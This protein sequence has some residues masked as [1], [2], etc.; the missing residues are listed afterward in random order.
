[1][2][3]K[4]KAIIIVIVAVILFGLLVATIFG[5]FPDKD[6]EQDIY[7]DQISDIILPDRDADLPENAE[8]DSSNASEYTAVNPSSSLGSGQSSL[9]REAQDLAEFF[10]ERYGTFSSDSNNAQIDD[11]LGFMTPSLQTEM[12]KNKLLQPDRSSHYEITTEIAGIETTEFSPANRMAE[13]AIVANRTED[14][15]GKIEQYQQEAVLILEQ[16]RA[17]VWKVDSILWGDRL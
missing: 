2:N 10:I 1:M 16:D 9:E 12:Q 3:P 17:G 14:F 15:S 13:F 11:L 6:E 8:F 7:Q 5:L 4:T